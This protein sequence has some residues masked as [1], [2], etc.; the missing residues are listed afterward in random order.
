MTDPVLVLGE[1]ARRV[2][3]LSIISTNV[4][5]G[6]LVLSFII[7]IAAHST[8]EY[9]KATRFTMWLFGDA[10]YRNFYK[11]KVAPASKIAKI[12]TYDPRRCDLSGFIVGD[13]R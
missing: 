5:V 6:F 13:L 9:W 2:F 1:L 11:K 10:P 12:T 3:Y 7:L 4:L 8:L